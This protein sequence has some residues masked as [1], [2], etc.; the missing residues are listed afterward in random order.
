MCS[1]TQLCPTLCN[2]MDCSPPGFSVHGIFQARI[3]EWVAISFYK[4]SSWPRVRIWVSWI[5]N[6]ILSHW[7]TCCCSTDKL[8]L[9]LCDPMDCS[10]PGFHVLHCLPEFAQTH[11][12]WVGDAIQPFHPPLPPSPPVLNLPQHQGLFQWV[13]CSHQV[14]KVLELSQGLWLTRLLCPWGSPGRNTGMGCHFLL[15]GIFPIQGLN[16]HL[17]RLLHW[18]LDPLPLHHLGSPCKQRVTLKIV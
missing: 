9:T 6:R 4:G 13:V 7:A 10:T 18:Q 16:L 2:L 8:C 5:S 1:I 3:L 17:L 14:A 11:V 12:H 15:Q